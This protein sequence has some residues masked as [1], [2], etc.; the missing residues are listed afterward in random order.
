MKKNKIFLGAQEIA[1]MMERLNN[2]FHQMGIKSD[3]F[4]LYGY[5]YSNRANELP[6]VKGGL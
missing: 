1:G 3:F 6:I 2:A 5:D 4:C